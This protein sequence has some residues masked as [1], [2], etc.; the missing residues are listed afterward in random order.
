MIFLFRADDDRFDINSGVSIRRLYPWEYSELVIEIN[1]FRYQHRQPF[2][3]LQ[4]LAEANFILEVKKTFLKSKDERLDFERIVDVVSVSS[5]GHSWVP[6]F[7]MRESDQT[8][9]IEGVIGQQVGKVGIVPTEQSPNFIKRLKKGLAIRN[10]AIF[11]SVCRSLRQEEEDYGFEFRLVKLFSSLEK[12]LGSPGVG[13][14]MKLQC[15]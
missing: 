12:L 4:T 7:V 13:G 3:S 11:K 5:K 14:G 1:Q 9:W 8:T 2:F 10:Q 15:C 6:I